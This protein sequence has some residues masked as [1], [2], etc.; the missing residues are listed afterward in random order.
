MTPAK[1]G[2]SVV[3][4][5]DIARGVLAGLPDTLGTLRGVGTLLRVRFGHSLSLGA[6]LEANAE[7]HAG[8]P[9]LLSGDRRW[10]WAEF[11]A[12]ANR[13]AHALRRA[14]VKRGDTVALLMENHAAGLACVAALAKLGAV[15]GMLNP[16]LRGDALRH[17]VRAMDP[18]RLVVAGECVESF[19]DL[20][21]TWAGPAP[22]WLE[23]H[24]EAPCPG[25]WAD[26]GGRGGG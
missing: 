1:P 10:T 18:A 13:L 20:A 11:N 23:G 12:W 17:S 22:F 7:A 19:G 6:V 26:L 25:G 9:A 4:L 3:H 16:N 14:G 2:A 8:Q 24:A 15:A 5:R 21:G